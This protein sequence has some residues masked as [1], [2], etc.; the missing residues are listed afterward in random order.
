[1]KPPPTA[2][3]T[4]S[5]APSMVRARPLAC[6]ALVLATLAVAMSVAAQ[7][8][9]P[10]GDELRSMY[11]IEVVRAE[12]DVQHH[13]ISAADAAAASATTPA[14]RQQWIDTSAELLQ[15]L[16]RLEIVR[17]RLQTY[18]LPRIPALDAAALGIAVRQG[19]ADFQESRAAADRCAL[20]CTPQPAMNP[21]CSA[22]CGNESPLGR[23]SA[24]YKPTWLPQ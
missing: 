9:P 14:L 10:S 18:M 15:G 7:Q 16:A 11:C 22:A 3:R 12:I 17:Y 13:L 20:E 21:A 19:N 1:M 2:L 5:A 6:T 24:C 4:A 23:L 8:H